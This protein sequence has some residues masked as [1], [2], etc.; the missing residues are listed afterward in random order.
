MGIDVSDQPKT[1]SR[2]ERRSNPV[3]RF[4]G[5]IST[6]LREVRWIIVLLYAIGGGLLMPLSLTVW[7]NCR[8]SSG[9]RTGWRRI[10]AGT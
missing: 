5:E 3:A 6:G 10:T 1:T 7:R 9:H 8:V 2:E 4:F